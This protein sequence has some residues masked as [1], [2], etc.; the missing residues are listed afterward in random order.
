METLVENR[1]WVRAKSVSR[2]DGVKES[3]CQRHQLEGQDLVHV[4]V[5]W[6]GSISKGRADHRVSEL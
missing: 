3:V 6:D 1:E 4:F 2:T 5:L